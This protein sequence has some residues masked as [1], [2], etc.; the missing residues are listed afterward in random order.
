M[1][2]WVQAVRSREVEDA[3]SDPGERLKRLIGNRERS[4]KKS[5]S[6]LTN[7]KLLGGWSGAS[8]TGQLIYRWPQVRRIVADIH[9]GLRRA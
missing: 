6:R 7:A 8:G 3:L 2:S 9:D 4:I 1:N 5:Q